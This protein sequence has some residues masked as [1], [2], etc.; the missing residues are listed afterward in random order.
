MKGGTTMDYVFFAFSALN[1]GFVVLLAVLLLARKDS[2]LLLRHLL[3]A[4]VVALTYYYLE[5]AV[6]SRDQLFYYLAN[7]LPQLLLLVFLALYLWRS[8]RSG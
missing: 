7:L 1:L 3:L 5:T 8:D 4:G 6:F 2:Q